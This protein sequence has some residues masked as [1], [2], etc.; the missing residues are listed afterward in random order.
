MSYDRFIY[1]GSS[2]DVQGILGP[3]EWL[4]VTMTNTSATVERYTFYA[5]ATTTSTVVR[6]LDITYK[7]ADKAELD[8]AKRIS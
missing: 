6:I 8:S 1:K 3:V 4:L 7:A 2:K 5:D